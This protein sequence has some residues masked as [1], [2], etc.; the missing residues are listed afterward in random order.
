[1]KIEKGQKYLCVKNGLVGFFTIGKIY[2]SNEDHVLTSNNGAEISFSEHQSRF[3]PLSFAKWAIKR[4]PK[5]AEMVNRWANEMFK[6]TMGYISSDKEYQGYLPDGY[7]EIDFET[8]KEIT[9]MGEEKESPKLKLNGMAKTDESVIIQLEDG[10]YKLYI[11]YYF[12]NSQVVVSEFN[13]KKQIYTQSKEI[14]IDGK[15]HGVSFDEKPKIFTIED[16]RNGKCA[17]E[18]DGTEQQLNR[19]LNYGYGYGNRTGIVSGHAKYYFNCD[20]L[21]SWSC[22]NTTDLPT[23]S[24]KLFLSQIEGEK[25]YEV[26]YDSADWMILG[27]KEPETEWQPKWGEEVEVSYEGG[28]WVN[29]IFV[30]INP[31]ECDFKYIAINRGGKR[32]QAYKQIRQPIHEFTTE[33]AKQEL[34]KLYNI[35]VN[36]VEIK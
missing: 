21:N 4:T 26:C 23:Q 27:Y 16:V 24:V 5:N 15:F 7:T 1:M 12:E 20:I 25:E 32:V 8:F 19:I 30:G 6:G 18:N 22:D 13:N 28:A 29:K 10:A 2:H 33:Q 9:G 11:E 17:I 35:N 3:V 31:I 34:A 14:G 36:Q